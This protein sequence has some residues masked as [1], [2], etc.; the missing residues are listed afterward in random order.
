MSTLTDNYDSVI[1]RIEN[2]RKRAASDPHTTLI[3][4]S[5]THPASDIQ[6]LYDHGVRIF[7]ENKVQELCDKYEVL[8]K[9]IEWHLIGHLQTNKVKYLIGKVALIHSVDSV[10]LAEQISKEAMKKDT[11]MDIL[12]EVNVS[13]ED[14]KFGLAPKQTEDAARQI[15]ALPGVRIKGLMTIAPFVTDPQENRE[16]FAKLRQLSVDIAEKNIDNVSM[17]FLSMGMTGDF[18]VAVEEGA[19]FVRVGTAIFGERD[20]T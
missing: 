8:P 11:V 1:K 2:A 20:Y 18:E 7:G 5:K 12:L 19:G 13:G 14:S 9:D 4:V 3:A 15:S 10:H 16:F 6:T 17:D